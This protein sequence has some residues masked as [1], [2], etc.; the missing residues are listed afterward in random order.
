MHRPS[1]AAGLSPRAARFHRHIRSRTTPSRR[2]SSGSPDP[3]FTLPA[4][5]GASMSRVL[6]RGAETVASG[7]V[8]ACRAVAIAARVSGDVR[9]FASTRAVPHTS[10]WNVI[11]SAPRATAGM[12]PSF[13]QITQGPGVRRLLLRRWRDGTKMTMP[14][15][16]HVQLS[17]S[18]TKETPLEDAPATKIWRKAT[19]P[20][21]ELPDIPGIHKRR[22]GLLRS[23]RSRTT[24]TR[25][26]PPRG[27]G[28]RRDRF[29]VRRA[30]L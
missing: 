5:H 4:R 14:K 27:R 12:G 7:L 8:V 20:R 18:V 25:S 9:G 11:E 26:L 22:R 28:L 3:G 10:H 1:N 24:P 2:D 15:L 17:Q 16:S 13:L 30:L 6:D 23:G 29:V 19:Q 21:G